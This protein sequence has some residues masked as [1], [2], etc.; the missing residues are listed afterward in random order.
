[1]DLLEKFLNDNAY[2]FPKG[3]PDLSQEEDKNIL[4]SLIEEVLNLEEQTSS[5]FDELI[6]Q[7]FEGDIPAV[8][9]KY[10]IPEG[11][12]PLKIEGKDQENFKKLYKVSPDKQVGNGEVSL[13]WLFNYEDP[14]N[15]QQI[16]KENRGGDAADLIIGDD[17]VEVKSYPRQDMKITLG[18]FKSDVESRKPIT[19][20]FGVLNLTG[21]LKGDR[22]FKSEVAFNLNDLKQS[23]TQILELNEVLSDPKIKQVLE[24]Y[25]VFKNLY[26]EI[27]F[28]LNLHDSDKSEELAKRVMVSLLATKLKSKPGEGNYVLNLIPSS[29]TDIM[30]HKIPQNIEE[31]LMS[32]SY[33]NLK[34]NTSVESAEI[35]L[36]YK[37]FD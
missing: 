10:I 6:S 16:A 24:E 32:Y 19:S 35:K 30:I 11:G 4:N 21:A 36:S 15:P 25:E 12:G 23:F 1:M 18:K 22:N 33:E 26:K 8:S 2:K 7:T 17:L 13:Y 9:K 29:P 20:L 14:S 28:L 37:L 3:Y 31:T 34:N 5:N 27:K